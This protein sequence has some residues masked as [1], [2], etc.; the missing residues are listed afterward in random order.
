[1]R[2]GIIGKGKEV[3]LP[4]ATPPT[5]AAKSIAFSSVTSS[6]M[7]L[8]WTN[9]IGGTGRLVLFSTSSTCDFLEIAGKLGDN[10]LPNYVSGFPVTSEV[11]WN[12]K[13]GTYTDI[14]GD[15]AYVIGRVT[16][17]SITIADL[18]SAT[19]YYWFILEYNDVTGYSTG[20]CTVAGT[21]NPRLKA[22]L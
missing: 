1:M 15:I 16:G 6:G 9:G 21:L 13:Q 22:T 12:N 5:V 17:R 19:N 2:R 14:S 11:S 8:T 4:P 20:Y 7:K 10:D 3:D 18:P